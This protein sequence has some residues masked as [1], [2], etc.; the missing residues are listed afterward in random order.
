MNLE[1]SELNKFNISDRIVSKSYFDMEPNTYY[2]IQKIKPNSLIAE[3]YSCSSGSKSYWT[4]IPFI[5]L[6]D[7]EHLSVFKE[8]NPEYFL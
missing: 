7:Y 8:Q 1:T 2:I 3:V 4:E 5:L 6:F